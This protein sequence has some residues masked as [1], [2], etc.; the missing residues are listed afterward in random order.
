M[1][2]YTVY[3][4]LK[5]K[6]FGGIGDQLGRR[7]RSI[8]TGRPR[9]QP[10]RDLKS[11]VLSSSKCWTCTRPMHWTLVRGAAQAQHRAVA[12]RGYLICSCATG[13]TTNQP[14]QPARDGSRG[15]SHSIRIITQRKIWRIPASHRWPTWPQPHTS[16]VLLDRRVKQ[17]YFGSSGLV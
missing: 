16:V 14:N 2:T 15:P 3:F 1:H 12:A 6:E 8:P 7:L 10:S 5:K 4:F 13:R 9:L 17:F 11:S